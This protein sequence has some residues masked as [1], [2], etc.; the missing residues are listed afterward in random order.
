MMESDVIRSRR[1]EIWTRLYSRF[2]LNPGG[3]EGRPNNV[4]KLIVPVTSVDDT[5][6]DSDLEGSTATM[7]VGTVIYFTVPDQELWSLFGYFFTRTSGDR[8]VVNVSLTEAPE[9]GG[10][11]MTIDLFTATNERALLFPQP[12]RIKQGWAVRMTG[13]GGTTDGSYAMLLFKEVEDL[14]F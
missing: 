4:S 13:S 14:S 8:D 5:L 9:D 10:A 11:S 6:R 1:Q 7:I 3:I 2:D 12:L